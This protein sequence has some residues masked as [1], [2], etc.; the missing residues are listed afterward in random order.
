MVEFDIESI[1]P[2]TWA[3]YPLTF[4]TFGLRIP[5]G[6]T[7]VRTGNSDLTKTCRKMTKEANQPI[8]EY[9]EWGAYRSSS[10]YPPRLVGIMIPTDIYNEAIEDYETRKQARLEKELKSYDRAKVKAMDIFKIYFPAMPLNERHAVF[11]RAVGKTS[12]GFGRKKGW[13]LKEKIEYAAKAYIKDR[14]GVYDTERIL[15]NWGWG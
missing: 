1:Q 11:E 7:F 6:Y 2:N 10:S 9:K 13:S 15:R 4:E 14:Y 5:T 8:V 12:R 3:D